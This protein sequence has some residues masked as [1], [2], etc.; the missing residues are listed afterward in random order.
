[1]TAGI[2]KQDLRKFKKRLEKMLFIMTK[3]NMQI[4]VGSPLFQV[5]HTKTT[6]S[7][8]EP[9]FQG[10]IELFAPGG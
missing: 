9:R 2:L 3:R 8:A 4:F 1:M 6:E 10:F 7:T 5:L